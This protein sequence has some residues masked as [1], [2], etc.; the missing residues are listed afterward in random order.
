MHNPQPGDAECLQFDGEIPADWR[1]EQGGRFSFSGNKITVIGC[2]AVFEICYRGKLFFLASLI[3]S[4][5]SLS[6]TPQPLHN[7]V[8]YNTTLDITL[9]SAGPQMVLKD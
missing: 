4:G 5:F 9:T 1:P 7:M 3:N 2:R 8:C 6:C